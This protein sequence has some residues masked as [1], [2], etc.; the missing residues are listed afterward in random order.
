MNRRSLLETLA[1]SPI[2]LASST[3]ASPQH[4][5]PRLTVEGLEVFRV[6]VN[7][8]G[9]WTIARLQTSGGITG[10]GECFAKR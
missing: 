2:A 5:L 9:N 4:G 7:R 10:L 8:R 1:I 3:F 6:K